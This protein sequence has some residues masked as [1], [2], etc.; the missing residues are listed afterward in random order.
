[1]PRT[2]K[3]S[4]KKP[5]RKIDRLRDGAGS[6]DLNFPDDTS[7]ITGMLSLD[8]QLLIVK[9]KGIYQVKMADQIDPD[10]TNIELPNTVQ[11][12]TSFGSDEEFIGKVLLTSH[13]LLMKGHL[14]S[15]INSNSVM[16]HIA[17][18]IKNI[19][20]MRVL[21]DRFGIEQDR[22]I[23]KFE[24]KI[25]QNRALI[26]PSMVNVEIRVREFFQ[27]ADHA[28]QKL[29]DVVKLFYLDVDRGGWKALKKRVEGE[30]SID[31]FVEYLNNIIPLL[32]R[33]RNARN[34]IEHERPDMKLIATDFSINSGNQLVPPIVELIHPK[35]PIDKLLIKEFMGSAL[36][37]IVEIVELMI[38][39][40]CARHIDNSGNLEISVIEIPEERRINSNIKYE[41]GVMIGGQ[42]VPLS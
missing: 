19:A 40:L 36:L 12:L 3:P 33:V 35:T 29:F 18:I 28:L 42:L 23:E 16:L 6:M 13:G 27:K 31:N 11:R 1:M 8:D 4:S 26:L 15:H 34:A 10:R 24:G 20:E 7:E 2:K 41:F 22:A 17:E 14:A 32:A 9:R 21:S 38:V 5:N 30:A 25:G 39:F 37:D